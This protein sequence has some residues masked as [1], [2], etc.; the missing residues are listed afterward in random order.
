MIKKRLL[1]LLEDALKYIKEQ[2]IWK[3]LGLISQIV[4]V[5]C[6]SSIISKV[7]T[8]GMT[9]INGREAS[10]S[11]G[12]FIKY[13]VPAIIC[14]VLRFIFDKKE[15]ESSFNASADVKKILRQK[16]YDKLLSLGSSYKEK[17]S[18][19]EVTQLMTEGVDQLETYFGLY[20][21]QL[22]YALI[23]PVILFIVINRNFFIIIK[24]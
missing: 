8:V 17:V 24:R 10:V 22:F 21:S 5:I 23:A 13:I 11:A 16:I 2:I 18:S 4:I 19:A 1:E 20:L 14:I 9:L 12:S 3:V 6:I 7:V 15:T